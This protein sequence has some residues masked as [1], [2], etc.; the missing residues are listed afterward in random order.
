MIDGM[1]NRELIRRCNYDPTLI[2]N[3]RRMLFNGPQ[4]GI[5]AN[6]ESIKMVRT[7]W[8]HYKSSGF[9]SIRI[10]D[11]LTPNNLAIV[12]TAVIDDLIQ[13]LPSKPFPV[14]SVHD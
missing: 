12:D 5:E 7:L 1:L 10:L 6:K 2:Q 8:N 9:L 4:N 11:Y 3:V 14:L 13:T